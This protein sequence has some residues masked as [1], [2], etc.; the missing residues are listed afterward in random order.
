MGFL[1]LLAC[2]PLLSSR[3]R[4]SPAGFDGV[5]RQMALMKM[6]ELLKLHSEPTHALERTVRSLCLQ[7]CMAIQITDGRISTRRRKQIGV[8]RSRCGSAHWIL[9]SNY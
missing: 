3:C 2:V 7:F 6:S 4:G 5:L 1:D 9:N 8:T